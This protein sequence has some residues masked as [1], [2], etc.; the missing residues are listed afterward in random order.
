MNSPAIPEPNP[1]CPAA[2]SNL[3][4]RSFPK[5]RTSPTGRLRTHS[6]ANKNG[7]FVDHPYLRLSRRLPRFQFADTCQHGGDFPRL[8]SASTA[9]CSS[10]SVLAISAVSNF[11]SAP[12]S[13][14]RSFRRTSAAIALMYS[15]NR[16]VERPMETVGSLT[17]PSV[18]L[19]AL[20][21]ERRA[22]RRVTFHRVHS[23]QPLDHFDASPGSN[24]P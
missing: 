1:V 17:K 10:R 2:P 8:T 15:P 7:R 9:F 18:R 22:I 6:R 12:C 16:Y 23:S 3:P 24:L 5:E 11:L 21:H 19:S 4:K 13:R 20:A 14:S